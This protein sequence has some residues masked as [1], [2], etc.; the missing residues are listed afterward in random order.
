MF[1]SFFIERLGRVGAF[2]L[3]TF[4]WVPCGALLLGT[5]E[6]RRHRCALPGLSATG[7]LCQCCATSL[8]TLPLNRL[9]TRPPHDM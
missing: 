9:P 8:S 4:G 1:V 3:S 2:N 5:G 7:C 6:Q